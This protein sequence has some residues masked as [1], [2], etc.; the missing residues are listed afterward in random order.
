LTEGIGT[1]T[2]GG[3]PDFRV[4][5]PLADFERALMRERAHAGRS[6]TRAPG[7]AGARATVSSPQQ[8]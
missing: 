2:P 6:P 8:V 5:T 3:K 4:V 7:R 1:S